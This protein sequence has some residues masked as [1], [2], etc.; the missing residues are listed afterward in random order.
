MSGP[1]S[2]DPR[3]PV[4]MQGRLHAG[5]E[6][7]GGRTVTWQ[8]YCATTGYP[9][10]PDAFDVVTADDGTFSMTHTPGSSE[11]CGEYEFYTV[12]PGDSMY[13]E[14][15]ES[16]RVPVSWRRSDVTLALP[17]SAYVQDE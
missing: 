13:A 15:K 11:A 17:P 7:L 2:V 5:D 4:T 6:A 12:W 3:T 14:A 16:H 9:A 1:E 10:D 8:P